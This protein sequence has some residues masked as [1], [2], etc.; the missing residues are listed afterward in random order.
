MEEIFANID[1]IETNIRLCPGGGMRRDVPLVY[2]EGGAG[3][4][5]DEKRSE[6]RPCI[7]ASICVDADNGIQ[8]SEPL[9]DV[10]RRN[11]KDGPS[12]LSLPPTGAQT[13]VYASRKRRADLKQDDNQLHGQQSSRPSS[14]A[15]H[16]ED[17]DENVPA[18]INGSATKRPL[19][20]G[21]K[22]ARK[23]TVN[24]L[25]EEISTIDTKLSRSQCAITES[26]AQLQ[27]SRQVLQALSDSLKTDVSHTTELQAQL[28][29]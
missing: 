8:W 7:K 10:K 18:A 6:D 3:K 24:S 16:L 2:N 12:P 22:D 28:A 19:M 9:I 1:E 20:N 4:N 13:D 26:G 21:I 14:S 17:N 11:V 23:G 27:A 15:E 5:G 25:I 29:V